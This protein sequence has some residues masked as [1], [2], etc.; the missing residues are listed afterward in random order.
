MLPGRFYKSGLEP[1]K[2]RRDWAQKALTGT[3]SQPIS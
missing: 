1:L 2:H 3:G